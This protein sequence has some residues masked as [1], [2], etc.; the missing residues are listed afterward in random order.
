MQIYNLDADK[1]TTGSNIPY[2]IGS[3]ATARIG[4]YVYLCGGILLSGRECLCVPPGG[5]GLQRGHVCLPVSGRK[6]QGWEQ[7]RFHMHAGPACPLSTPPPRDRSPSTPCAV[8]TT[9]KCVKY[10]IQQDKWEQGVTSMPRGVNHAAAATDGQK[11]YVAGGRDGPNRV[12]P[13][14]NTMQVSQQG[15]RGRAGRGG[16]GWG[17]WQGRPLPGG[18][19]A[20]GGAHVA[21]RACLLSTHPHP[22]PNP[23]NTSH[24][25]PPAQIYN[26][27]TN[28]WSMGASLPEARGGTGRA[29][30]QGGSLYVFGGET[31]KTS[32]PG[33]T[34]AGTYNRVDVYNIQNDKWSKVRAAA[35]FS[36]RGS[37]AG[38][39]R[40]RGALSGWP[41]WLLPH[42]AP[43]R[44]S[45]VRACGSAGLP[46]P[47]PSSLLPAS[48]ARPAGHGH[49]G[50]P[51]RHLPGGR[52]QG[53]HLC[54]GRRRQA[55]LQ[56]ERRQRSLQALIGTQSGR[57]GH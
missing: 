11:M 4:G 26:P 51:P 41:R 22:P 30:V 35:L 38:Q 28:K 24:P 48:C 45:R 3:A 5:A 54:D 19:L 27:D 17:G 50:G 15:W 2:G 47:P 49:A 14:F 1:W 42:A 13:G 39:Q 12:S 16:A 46:S 36:S 55:R 7:E 34:G 10:N 43:A 9:N 40:V 56:Q 33:L 57:A 21:A 6:Q 53:W 52:R 18:H 20:A 23:P 31:T 25:A 29:V 37:G 44:P 8:T 32:G